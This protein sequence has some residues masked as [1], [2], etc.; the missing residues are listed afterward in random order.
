[1]PDRVDAEADEA[2]VAAFLD[3]DRGAFDALYARWAPRITGYA[4]RMLGRQEDAEEVCVET[5]TRVVE[6]RWRASG[7]FRAWLFTVAH[8]LCL[9][10]LR[11]RTLTA[12]VLSLF[13]AAP[14]PAPE[15][16]EGALLQDERAAHLERAVAALPHRHRAT[17]LL[18]SSQ[19]LSARE[20][21]EVLGLSDQQIR[22]Q[23]SYARRLLREQLGEEEP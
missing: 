18:V 22:S 2:L 5:F 1:M 6:G 11:R 19:G 12:R 14:A 9:E 13:G 8:R 23:L 10:R 7:A 3:G 4:R 20:A 15:G 21:G 16:P 17:L